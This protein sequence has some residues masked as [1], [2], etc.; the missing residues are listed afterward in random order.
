MGGEDDSITASLRIRWYRRGERMCGAHVAAVSK[1][2]DS[3]I[4]TLAI[5][6]RLCRLKIEARLA[7][8]D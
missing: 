8:T 3:E 2:S 7:K 1:P 5:P 4:P 6:T